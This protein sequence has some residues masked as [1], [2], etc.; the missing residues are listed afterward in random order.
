MLVRCVLKIT[1]VSQRSQ[2]VLKG[3]GVGFLS[4]VNVL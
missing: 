1:E 3:R 4:H 2:D